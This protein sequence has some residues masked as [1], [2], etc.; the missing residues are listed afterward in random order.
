[1]SPTDYVVKSPRSTVYNLVRDR[2]TATGIACFENVETV[3]AAVDTSRRQALAHLNKLQKERSLVRVPAIYSGICFV[4]MDPDP[5]R[6]EMALEVAYSSGMEP[7]RVGQIILM[8]TQGKDA[9]ETAQAIKGIYARS[10][11]YVVDRLR[12]VG[13]W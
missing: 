6:R 8:T 9:L 10:V 5:K 1:M 3:A 13:Y 2:A 4:P 11:Q 7:H 12:E